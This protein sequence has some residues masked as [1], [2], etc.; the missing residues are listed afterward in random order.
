MVL[1]I[2]NKQRNQRR[3]G[4]TTWPIYAALILF[5][6]LYLVFQKNAALSLI[7]GALVFIVLIAL[8]VVE[9]ANGVKQQGVWRNVLE[10][11]VAVAIVVA[12]WYGMQFLLGT[13]TPIDVVPSCSMLPA[14]QRGDMILL[15][16]VN[17]ESIT[18]PTINVTKS[19]FQAA[20]GNNDSTNESLECV[21]YN[22]TGTSVQVSQILVPG[23]S[24]G[25]LKDVNGHE[26]IVPNA[27]QS[28]SLIR[29]ECGLTSEV[30]TNGNGAPVPA[31][32]GVV[33]TKGITI[34]N[35]TVNTTITGDK[36]NSIVV[37]QTIPQDLFYMEGDSYIVHRAYALLNVSGK[38]YVLT[39]GDNNPGL[40][41]QYGNYP[42]A[43][44]SV[45]G[46]VLFSIPYLGY[47]KL[48]LSNNFVEPS[49]CNST[50]QN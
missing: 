21:A 15:Q 27:S 17:P 4:I 23:Y 3:Q 28:N 41:I 9:I 22:V 20:F 44:S 40:D 34:G 42:A 32:Y 46:K 33:Y 48:I 2:G 11:V 37:Y 29:Y 13:S 24:I 38:Y 31:V 26:S 39:K 35:Q 8:I 6:V 5:F 12:I 47:L 36:N 30:I 49:G 7:F 14:L 16:G 50:L 25:L 43:L 45:Q 19:E 10:L 18:A 1:G